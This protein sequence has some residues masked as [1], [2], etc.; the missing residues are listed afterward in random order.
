MLGIIGVK[1]QNGILIFLFQILVMIFCAIFLAIGIYSIVLPKD[2]F[3]KDCEDNSNSALQAAKSAYGY[4]EENFC[5][6]QGC[7][8]TNASIS[9]KYNP[10]DQ[11]IVTV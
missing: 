8:L 3:N 1:K 9:D 5:K 7:G 11:D 2:I 4:A 6:T 10:G